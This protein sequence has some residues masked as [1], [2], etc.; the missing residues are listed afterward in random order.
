MRHVQS[1]G[2]TGNVIQ[3]YHYDSIYYH[4]QNIHETGIFKY[5]NIHKI[6]DLKINSTK[7]VGLD[8]AG[9]VEGKFCSGAAYSDRFGS[10]SNVFVQG[11]IKIEFLESFAAASLNNDKLRFNSGT[12]CK[13]SD[14]NCID[15]EG[16]YTFWPLLPAVDCFQNQYDVLCRRPVTKIT[17]PDQEK[18][19]SI[20]SDVVSFA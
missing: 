13:F 17:S 10:R 7:S 16:G 18:I 15:L 19:F 4:Y 3:E 20:S 14:Q 2:R 8:L 1:L 12:V 5:D 9:K 11:L 6:A